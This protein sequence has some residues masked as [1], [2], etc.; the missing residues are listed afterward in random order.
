MMKG[1]GSMMVYFDNKLEL[2]AK[3]NP[4]VCIIATRLGE[5][6]GLALMPTGQG[7]VE[8]KRIGLVTK[9]PL[10]W[11]ENGEDREIVIH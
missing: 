3:E 9:I 1:G 4:T 7:A 6:V 8:Y 10:E 5:G 2:D 11:C